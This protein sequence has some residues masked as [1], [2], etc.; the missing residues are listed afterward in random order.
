[1][2]LNEVDISKYERNNATTMTHIEGYDNFRTHYN[3]CFL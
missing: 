2:K 1:M 3:S